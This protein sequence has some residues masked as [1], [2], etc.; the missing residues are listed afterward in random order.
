MIAPTGGELG[1]RFSSVLLG[2]L[3][4]GFGVTSGEV[5]RTRHFSSVDFG[6]DSWRVM[7]TA[8]PRFVFLTMIRCSVVVVE[9]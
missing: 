3:G 2:A 9:Y 7:R 1:V 6:M 4:G 8:S 5:I